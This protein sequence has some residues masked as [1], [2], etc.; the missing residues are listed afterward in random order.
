[1]QVRA[2]IGFRQAVAADADV[3]VALNAALFRE[4]AGERD[5][6]I[7][8]T[9]PDR[10]GRAYFAEV[11]ADPGGVCYLATSDD[12]PVGYLIGRISE[13]SSVRPVRVAELESMY[14]HDRFRS[15]GLGRRLVEQFLGWARANHASRA[16]VVAYAANERAIS[17]YRR[18]GFR[19]RSLSLEMSV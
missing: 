9:W 2:P 11:L 5:P 3:V 15:Q 13:P 17:F 14:V 16:A 8:Q 7:D 12:E 10:E 18:A 6:F 1:M 4:D 19:P